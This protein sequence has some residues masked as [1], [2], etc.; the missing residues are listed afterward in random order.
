MPTYSTQNSNNEP[1]DGTEA[2][3][4]W[5]YLGSVHQLYMYMMYKYRDY[6]VAKKTGANLSFCF[7]EWKV[8]I[9]TLRFMILYNFDKYLESKHSKE[10]VSDDIKPSDYD[11]IITNTDETHVYK[12]MTKLIYWCQADGIFK[13]EMEKQNPMRW[14]ISESN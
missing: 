5:D 12:L 6:M 10:E 2:A 1:F 8:S 14:F 13:L 4:H 7:H 9:S 3:K 11:N